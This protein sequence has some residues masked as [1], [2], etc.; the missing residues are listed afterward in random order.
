V[1]VTVVDDRPIPPVE[2]T[3][4]LVDWEGE[5]EDI[6]TQ[7]P[8]ALSIDLLTTTLR[9]SPLDFRMSS[10]PEQ[11]A[12]LTTNLVARLRPPAERN[13]L[14]RWIT[15]W[16]LVETYDPTTASVL[17][18]EC[19]VPHRG[20]AYTQ[21]QQT[22]TR[23]GSVGIKLLGSGFDTG[24]EVTLEMDDSSPPRKKCAYYY[25]DYV[26]RPRLYRKASQEVWGAEFVKDAGDRPVT[27]Q[28]CP[29]C[30]IHPVNIDKE[31]YE[32]DKH[33]DARQDVV[34][35]QR[36]MKLDW[37]RGLSLSLSIP[38]P[39]VPAVTLPISATA[40]SE[41]VWNVHYVF[42]PR[43]FYQGYRPRGVGAT[44]LRWAYGRKVSE[45]GW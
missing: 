25:H 20:S 23:K 2:E 33:F 37:K 32:I 19:H 29:Y 10:E 8:D 12:S 44:T 27:L 7:L 43:W 24:R 3:L 9:Q 15:G 36:S 26:V 41:D 45:V 30:S 6:V 1:K 42:P 22:K 31:Q 34:E 40:S 13:K 18:Y 38:V 16:K 28:E 14:M 5:P 39:H 35:L 4:D 11:G 21:T 17:W